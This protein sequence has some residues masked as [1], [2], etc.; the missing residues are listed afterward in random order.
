MNSA[1]APSA[2][3][4]V[5]DVARVADFYRGL[6]SMR[7][8]HAD[9]DHVVLGV[10]GF[11]LVIHLI[12]GE[13]PTTAPLQPREDSYSKICLP[14]ASIDAARR[15]AATLGGHVKGAEHEWSARGFRACDGHDPEGNIVQVREADASTQCLMQT[16]VP[17]LVGTRCTLRAF[18]PADAPSITRHADD[19]QVAFDLFDGFPQPYT[20]ELAHAWC[21]NDCRP[22]IY[23][24][25][26][27]I[28]IGGEAV[29]SC[30]VAP[31]KGWLRCNA[32]VGY[33]IGRAFWRRGIGSEMLRLLSA[34]AWQALP[35]VTRLY[36]PIFA[37]NDGSQ[38]VAR[39]AG[40]VL[41]G[42]MP[43]SAIKDG[44][45]IDRVVYGLYRPR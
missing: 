11:E 20:L 33:W 4:F 1:P 36:A 37:R 3:I 28:D 21:S 32:E 5:A 2:V 24:H 10:A 30:S 26:F 8:L 34:W 38:G 45:L 39:R 6:A 40:Y 35:D 9:D 41:E 12:R 14:V 44:V 17:T 18:A 42:R 15:I 23:G 19:A 43:Q 22:A 25:V 27:A 16:T 13:Y 31:D 7:T 29:G